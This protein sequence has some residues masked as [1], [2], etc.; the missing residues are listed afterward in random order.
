MQ[1]ATFEG[2]AMISS[3]ETL[4]ARFRDLGGVVCAAIKSD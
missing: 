2:R 4:R 3:A 1:I